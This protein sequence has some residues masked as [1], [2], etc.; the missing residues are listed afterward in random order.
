MKNT[1]LLLRYVCARALYTHTSEWGERERERERVRFSRKRS[2]GR[3]KKNVRI[4]NYRETFS[5]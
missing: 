3:I 2:N 1:E 5:I 4:K